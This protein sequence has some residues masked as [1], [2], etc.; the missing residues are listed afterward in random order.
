M[1]RDF[2]SSDE[3]SEYISSPDM[4]AFTIGRLV[5]ATL[6]TGRSITA[7]DLRTRLSQIAKGDTQDLPPGV[8]AEMAKGALRY[9]A[10]MN[11]KL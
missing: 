2:S 3:L 11:G 6:T 5:I 7:K 10:S 1:T 4:A 8:N 9:L